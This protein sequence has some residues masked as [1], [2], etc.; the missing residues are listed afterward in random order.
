MS[1]GLCWRGHVGGCAIGQDV[2]ASELRA[3]KGSLSAEVSSEQ[4]GCSRVWGIDAWGP[5]IGWTSD[6]G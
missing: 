5:C 4:L 1:R 6:A 2:V 3:P